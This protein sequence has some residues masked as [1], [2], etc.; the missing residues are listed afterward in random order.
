MKIVAVLIIAAAVF[1]LCFLADKLF[2]RLFR[3][4][5]Q[6]LS[7][8]SVRFHKRYCTV[9]LILFA[10][11]VA[12]I[13]TGMSEEPILAIGGWILTVT[14]IGLVVYYL[15]FGVYYDDEQFLV[16]SFGRRRTAYY[17]RDIRGQQ[18]YSGSVNTVIELYMHDGK[19]V[20][21]SY[22]MDGTTA[23]LDHA[24]AMW[25]VQTGKQKEDCPFYDPDNSCWFPPV[26]V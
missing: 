15:A 5:P 24:S 9:G 4:R 2:T 21:L 26:E 25:L 8:K 10:L 17:Y 7:G 13:F 23:F 18:L 16:M 11:G 22:S 20:Q 1:G 3:N 12:A 14:G 6:H 19:S